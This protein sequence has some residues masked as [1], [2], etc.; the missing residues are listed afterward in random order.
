MFNQVEVT[1]LSKSCKNT[2][3]YVPSSILVIPNS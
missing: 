1:D 3:I 2:E